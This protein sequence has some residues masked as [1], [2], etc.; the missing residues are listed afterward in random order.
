MFVV[1]NDGFSSL[2]LPH[3]AKKIEVVPIL[4]P[5]HTLTRKKNKP[6]RRLPKGLNRKVFSVA[7]IRSAGR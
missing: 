2:S 6:F 4:T 7:L 1:V 3:P 5:M